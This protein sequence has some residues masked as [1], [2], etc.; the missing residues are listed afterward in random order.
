MRV[1]NVNFITLH[2]DTHDT[3][4]PGTMQMLAI[5]AVSA[6]LLPRLAGK[7]QASSFTPMI[8]QDRRRLRPMT[9]RYRFPYYESYDLILPDKLLTPCTPAQR[10]TQDRA[11]MMGYW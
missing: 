3:V 6:N 4:Y 11:G 2:S 7:T 9:I 1:V 8:N 10:E 5:L